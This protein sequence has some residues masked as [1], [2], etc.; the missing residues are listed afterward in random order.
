[1]TRIF[2]VA[3]TYVLIT[4]VIEKFGGKEDDRDGVDSLFIPGGL[5]ILEIQQSSDKLWEP[6]D[7]KVSGVFTGGHIQCDPHDIC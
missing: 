7:W 2:I 4:P 5:K 1:M 6:W 3:N